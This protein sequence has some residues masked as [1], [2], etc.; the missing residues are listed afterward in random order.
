MA[1]NSNLV[2]MS[3]KNRQKRK[4]SVKNRILVR[5]I[6]K[7]FGQKCG[8]KIKILFQTENFGPK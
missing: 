4:V 7:F 2:K 5:K 8:S 6:Q 1:K 3:I